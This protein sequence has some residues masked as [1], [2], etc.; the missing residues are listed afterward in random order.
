MRYLVAYS[1][2]C[3][4]VSGGWRVG[5]SVGMIVLNEINMFDVY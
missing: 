3:A 1:I 2:V 5:G 4:G